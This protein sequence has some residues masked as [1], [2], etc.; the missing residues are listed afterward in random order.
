MFPC[1][2]EEDET[3]M[4]DTEENDEMMVAKKPMM[5]TENMY[6]T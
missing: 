2:A 4:E 6:G 5:I 3:K 1:D